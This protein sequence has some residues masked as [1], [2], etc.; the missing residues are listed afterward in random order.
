M[1][2]APSPIALV[3]DDE[4]PVT[5]LGPA[6]PDVWTAADTVHLV[7]DIKI[8]WRDRLSMLV[9]GLATIHTS[10]ACEHQSIGRIRGMPSHLVVP[11]FFK[12]T[13][14]NG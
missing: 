7:V 2:D 9:H 1:I 14:S 6:T 3:T 10:A 4:E 11:P 8:S 5:P 13:R 12:V